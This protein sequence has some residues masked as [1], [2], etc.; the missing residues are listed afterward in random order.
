[1][2]QILDLGTQKVF[3]LLE[4]L[5][6]F[7][8]GLNIYVLFIYLWTITKSTYLLI[9]VYVCVCVCVDILGRVKE[10]GSKEQCRVR[11]LKDVRSLRNIG[12]GRIQLRLWI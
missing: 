5:Q 8:I 2:L 1:M 12:T 6:L 9:S 10:V 3:D 11:L 7:V 4:R